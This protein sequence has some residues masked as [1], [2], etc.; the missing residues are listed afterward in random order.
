MHRLLQREL[1]GDII[2][3]MQDKA[4]L[5]GY[6]FNHCYQWSKSGTSTAARKCYT[7]MLSKKDSQVLKTNL[8]MTD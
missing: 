5:L 8:G 6:F 7:Y 3:Q 1:Q 2:M 4:Q